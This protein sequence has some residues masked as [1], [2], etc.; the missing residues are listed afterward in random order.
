MSYRVLDYVGR[1]GVAEVYTCPH[2]EIF[3]VTKVL[4]I[5]EHRRRQGSD[6][7]EAFWLRDNK[8]HIVLFSCRKCM[9]GYDLIADTNFI[10]KHKTEQ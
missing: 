1:M 10:R 6:E 3:R 5:R 7:V 8:G 4:E 2:A 9:T